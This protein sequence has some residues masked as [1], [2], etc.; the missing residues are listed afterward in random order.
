M[1]NNAVINKI[2]IDPQ[3]KHNLGGFATDILMEDVPNSP[4]VFTVL[5]NKAEKQYYG[6]TYLFND[7]S[8]IE[9]LPEG[10]YSICY[11]D[12]N[13]MEGS[14][15]L[16]IGTGNINS[17]DNSGI[18]GQNLRT[19][20]DNQLVIG[21]RTENTDI[22]SNIALSRA[23]FIIFNPN[24]T[25][26]SSASLDPHVNF[27]VGTDGVISNSPIR[28]NNTN[29]INVNVAGNNVKYF[30][31]NETDGIDTNLPFKQKAV[32][33]GGLEMPTETWGIFT[34][35]KNLNQDSI[36]VVLSV[37][38]N[39]Q[40]VTARA[41]FEHY[42]SNQGKHLLRIT[43]F[44]F[45]QSITYA[46]KYSGYFTPSGNLQQDFI[47]HLYYLQRSHVVNGALGGTYIG[48]NGDILSTNIHI[49]SEGDVK[50]YIS[51]LADG[52]ISNDASYKPH[53]EIPLYLKDDY[54]TTL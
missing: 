21:E 44:N 54:F 49:Q 34:G 52:G 51:L 29:G 13:S 16:I 53:F 39:N 30:K 9:N 20:R 23:D 48:W 37:G 17:H 33:E 4:T 43:L 31:V 25:D 6:D 47:S 46:N 32:F 45:N 28:V 50:V 1:A 22:S 8:S 36:G 35:P 26:I 5:N 27:L 14:N 11:G 7:S 19:L 2:Y 24:S 38:S 40:T 18:I 41:K 12:N 3:D 15:S 42:A 10:S